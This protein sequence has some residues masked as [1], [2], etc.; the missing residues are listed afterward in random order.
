MTYP[1]Y[2]ALAASRVLGID[3]DISN[4]YGTGAYLVHIAIHGG[5]I[6]PPTSQLAEYCAGSAGA[7]YS[8]EALNELTA[9]D[10]ELPATSFDEPFCL[11]NVGNSVRTISWR[12]V[13]DQR[14]TEEVTYISGLDDVLVALIAQELTTAGF[15]TDTPPLRFEGSDPQNIANRNRPRAGVQLDL[16]RSLRRALY[17]DGDLSAEAV[18]NPANRLPAF[19]TYAD[20]IK[21]AAA[22]VPLTV[23]EPETPPVIAATGPADTGVSVAM[24]TPFAID[25]TGAVACTNDARE[26]LLDRV[27]ALVG[28]LPGERVMRATYGVPTS[29]ALFEISAEVAND[30]L[31]RAVLD[32]VAEFEPSA[33]VS[34][35]SATVINSL[36]MVD[37]SVQVS[38]ADVPGAEADQTRTVGV[39]VGGTVVS[40]PG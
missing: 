14:E 29:S 17:A 18:A 20:A 38:R 24:R 15:V 23:V 30:Q 40:T 4:R 32:A 11:V 7:Y 21:R 22:Q 31:Q 19:F 39:L 37:I 8:F 35:V 25:H 10:L 13:E 34:A 2:R 36:G 12:G 1:H 27:H 26:Q 28:T 16:T 9:A 5:A 33:V 6:E 3:Y